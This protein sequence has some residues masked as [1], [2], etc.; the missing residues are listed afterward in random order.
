MR[1]FLL[2]ST[3]GLIGCIG[4]LE[5][6]SGTNPNPNGENSIAKKMFEQ[7]VFPILRNPGS[8]ADCS[9]CHDEKAPSGNL[10][11]FV[12]SG[13][14][15]SYATV[16]SFQAVVG[17]FTPATA[18][19]LTKIEATH[20]GRKYTADQKAKITEWLAQEVAE[21]AG[22]TAPPPG[23]A[24]GKTVTAR[25]VNEFSGC[26]DIAD[27]TAAG[28]STAWNN[29]TADGSACKTC[30]ATGAYGMIVS[31]LAE[32]A[33]QGGPPG[34]FTTISTNKYFMVQWFTVDLATGTP[35]VVINQK[36][37]EGVSKGLAPHAQHPRFNALNN[38]GMTALKKFYD[39]TM[40][41]VEAK[42]CGPTKL[43]PPA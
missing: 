10:T 43:N 18:Q 32:T 25:L 17:N 19:I 3:I 31:G 16:T 30:H 34:M 1:P 38:P 42:T 11:G 24:T 28:M 14:S 29:M 20:E 41:K 35:K 9:E 6:G 8:D 13:V 12:A 37:F 22:G 23:D 15:N 27:Y 21:R 39:A 2:A 4:Q 33:P 7:S 5:T 26:M 40:Q 36:S